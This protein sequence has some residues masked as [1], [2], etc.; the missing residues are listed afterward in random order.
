MRAGIPE[1]LVQNF[2][3]EEFKG[4]FHKI[5]HHLAHLYSAFNVSPF[6]EAICAMHSSVSAFLELITRLGEL[7][8]EYNLSTVAVTNFTHKF[9]TC[10]GGPAS[11][12]PSP[13][14]CR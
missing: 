9:I 7:G 3:G 2:P 4:Q 8:G 11:S 6:E 5:E 14:V 13:S 10:D 12:Y 1:L